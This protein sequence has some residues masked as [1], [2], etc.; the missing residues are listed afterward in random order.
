MVES[1]PRRF[2]WFTCKNAASGNNFTFALHAKF[3]REVTME[4]SVQRLQVSVFLFYF[5]IMFCF[6]IYLVPCLQLRFALGQVNQ[7]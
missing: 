2:T 5:V 4:F 3:R 6:V 7:N 1:H